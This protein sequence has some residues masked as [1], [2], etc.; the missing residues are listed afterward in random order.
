MLNICSED[1]ARRA[2]KSEQP[3]IEDRNEFNKMADSFRELRK[4][5]CAVRRLIAEIIEEA[6]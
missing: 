4:E 6:A 3:H 2:A 1:E 5:R